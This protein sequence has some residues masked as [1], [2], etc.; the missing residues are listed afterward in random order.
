[1]AVSSHSSEA[2][3]QAHAM[4]RARFPLRFRLITVR[5]VTRLS[6]HMISVTFGGDL[7]GFRS[8][9]FD[10]HV[11][12]LLPAPG[13]TQPVLPEIGP[14][15]TPVLG[16]RDLIARDYTPRRFDVAS[17]ELDVEFAVH[18][19][20]PATAWA[21]KAA[22]GQTI[23]LGG[24]RGSMVI[25]SDFDWYL[26]AGDDAALPA[27]ARRLES[28]PAGARA[29]VFAEVEGRADE[30]PLAAPAGAEIRWLHRGDVEPGLSG[31]LEEALSS[32]TPPAGDGH[33]WIAAE[34]A[35]ARRLR[36]QFLARHD[37]PKAWL[38]AA[39]YWHRG[40]A[41]SHERIDD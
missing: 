37:H 34:A 22:P 24:P 41:D 35:V 21:L 1:M 27:I 17:G 5:R 13:E 39:A 38:K 8:D 28:L 33:V 3:P 12:L 2:G 40:I 16:N 4:T 29:F 31:V 6:P 36:T 10:D 20:G 14:D 15:G 32:F 26:L 23:G 30:L 18:E 7:E 19:A 9:G 25:A 11:K